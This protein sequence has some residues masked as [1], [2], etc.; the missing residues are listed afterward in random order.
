MTDE[1]KGDEL[2]QKLEELDKKKAAEPPPELTDEVVVNLAGMT[3][4]EYAQKIGREAKKHRVPMR[5]LEK[6]VDAARTELAPE[7]LLEP[8]WAV[9]PADDPVD[10]AQLFTEIE[11]RILR[12]VVMPADFAFAVALWIGQSWIH[13]HA[14]YSPILFVTSPEKDSGKSTL[15]G[16]IGFLVRRSLLSVGI[17]AAALY[18]S[19]E[20]WRPSFVIDEADDAFV[21]NPDLRQVVNSGWTRGQ[22]VVRC[23]PD[24]NEPRKFSTFCPKAIASKGKKAPETILSRAIFIMQKR[25][26]KGE[27]LSHFSHVDDDGF[28]R[29][30][31]QLAR[32]AEDNGESLGHAQPAQPEGF[33]NRMASNWQLMF[34]I[35]D[36]LGE[37]VGAR[38][39]TVAQ[40]LAGAADLASA[41]VELLREVR[42][43]FEASTLDYVYSRKL[44][45][46]LHAD[47]EKPWVEYGR[48]G[49]PI[50]A[51]GVAKLLREY[52]IVSKAVGP[53]E[54][55]A[56]GYRRADFE[57]AWAR[58][59]TPEAEGEAESGGTPPSQPFT[60][61]PPCNDY[62]KAEKSAVHQPPGERQKIDPFPSEIN[63][64]N[65]WT[66]DSNPSSP[67]SSFTSDED[68][69][70][71][72]RRP[73]VPCN[74]CGKP[75][76]PTEPVVLCGQ[77]GS[78]GPY[79]QRCWTEERTKGRVQPQEVGEPEPVCRRC[80]VP[81]NATPGRR[82][83]DATQ[84]GRNSPF[85]L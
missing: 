67:S 36:S 62:G 30:R 47:P 61:S 76:T 20:K 43:V 10:A 34:A 83:I 75:A 54:A 22:G 71:L 82:M 81:G 50:T 7:T 4:L 51:E 55:R 9:Q 32:W 41:G 63:T 58:Y 72:L 68:F 8:H 56:K 44:L 45:D 31:S 26:T 46:H 70:D 12:H 27:T 59:L 1:K 19:I 64:V 11:A 35:A 38:A 60:R 14:T 2:V 69:P 48:A 3:P 23:E 66:A 79:H 18:R 53:K 15:M 84:R 13:E 39:R 37:E 28:A 80:G 74:R 57:D 65:G 85:Q 21:D 5:L 16:I 40:R 29:L 33:I 78:A 42:A 25:R 24:T 49:K 73:P 52:N 6:A 77:N 17:S